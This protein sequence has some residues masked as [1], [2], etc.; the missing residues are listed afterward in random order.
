[1]I[2]FGSI[3][4]IDPA[5]LKQALLAKDIFVINI[6]NMKMDKILTLGKRIYFYV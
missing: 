4:K 5:S 2:K 1:M 3:L 6:E